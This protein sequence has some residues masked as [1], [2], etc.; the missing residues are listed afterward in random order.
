MCIDYIVK[1]WPD[2]MPLYPLS[3][4]FTNKLNQAAVIARLWIRPP[5]KYNCCNESLIRI[6]FHPAKQNSTVK[7]ITEREINKKFVGFLYAKLA[8][9]TRQRWWLPARHKAPR[10]MA[11]CS[12][13]GTKTVGFLHVTRHQ[14]CWLLARHRT[15]VNLTHPSICFSQG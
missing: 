13:Q 1:A 15:V 4:D 2:V 9:S 8:F 10:L 6:L 5:Q 12:S 11:S 7:P 14:D 3:V